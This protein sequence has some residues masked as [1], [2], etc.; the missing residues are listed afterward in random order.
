MEGSF[1]GTLNF[2]RVSKVSKHDT[3]PGPERSRGEYTKARR[4]NTKKVSSPRKRPA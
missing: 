3:L 1:G 2:Y 4:K